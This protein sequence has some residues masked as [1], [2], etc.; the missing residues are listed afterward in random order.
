MILLLL[1]SDR[2]LLS[3][4]GEG[5]K[6]KSGERLEGIIRSVNLVIDYG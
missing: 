5:I 3:S 2:F 1:G 6:S 4:K